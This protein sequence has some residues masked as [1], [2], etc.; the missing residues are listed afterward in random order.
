METFFIVK[1]ALDSFVSPLPRLCALSVFRRPRRSGVPRKREDS[2]GL[3]RFDN[4]C[5]W[6]PTPE[7]SV[8]ACDTR[9]PPWLFVQPNTQLDCLSVWWTFL[10]IE[11]LVSC[12]TAANAIAKKLHSHW[13]LS[14]VNF[15]PCCSLK[16]VPGLYS[17]YLLIIDEDTERIPMPWPRALR[18]K[19]TASVRR[20]RQLPLRH[21]PCAIDERYSSSTNTW[22]S[23]YRRSKKCLHHGNNSKTN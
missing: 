7:A 3:N 15:Y 11:E 21:S 22:P 9:F 1:I 8:I 18:T 13:I 16:S 20:F 6:Q 19:F 12:Q 23:H 10:M 4:F 17:T 5:V 2:G 14:T